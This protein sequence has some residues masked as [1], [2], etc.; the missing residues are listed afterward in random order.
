MAKRKLIQFK[1]LDEHKQGVALLS[2]P[3]GSTL[4]IFRND[5]YVMTPYQL[6]QLDQKNIRYKII[7]E[8]D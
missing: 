1:T 2:Q 6:Q 3:L 5:Q 4:I 8:I 7:K